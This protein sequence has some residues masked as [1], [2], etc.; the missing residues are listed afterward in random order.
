VSTTGAI[1]IYEQHIKSL[2][3]EQ[4]LELLALIAQH[5]AHPEEGSGEPRIRNIMDLY[6]VGRR[7]LDG[8]DAQEFVNKLRDEWR[9]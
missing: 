1:N 8:S 5:L 2:P 4:Q 7:S 9:T 6:G 3:A